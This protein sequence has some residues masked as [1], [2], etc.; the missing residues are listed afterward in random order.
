MNRH[1]REHLQHSL[2]TLACAAALIGTSL[3]PMTVYAD[4]KEEQ[5]QGTVVG[6]YAVQVYGIGQ[7]T[8]IDGSTGGLTFGPALGGD[9]LN[10]T[11]GHDPSGKTRTGN[12]HRCVN[13]DTWA[14]II[15]YSY[16]DPEIY[17]QCVDKGCIALVPITATAENSYAG[18]NNDYVLDSKMAMSMEGGASALYWELQ[19]EA[20][21]YAAVT[22]DDEHHV[23]D[24]SGL[25]WAN[26][27]IRAMLNGAQDGDTGAFGGSKYS[28]DSDTH[29]GNS[30]SERGRAV[31]AQCANHFAHGGCQR[32]RGRLS[33]GCE[34]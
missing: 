28:Y 7:D 13:Q 8:M 32:A 22:I 24:C 2:T 18:Y 14:Q 10:V 25:T 4:E 21:Q 33:L 12:A 20:R 11:L 27:Q 9:Y 17:E 34:W 23:M 19:D 5:V 1:H 30:L 15:D 6:N 31:S 29:K 16:D 3:A 26:S